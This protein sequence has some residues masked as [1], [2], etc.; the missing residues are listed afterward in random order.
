MHAEAEGGMKDSII[1]IKPKEIERRPG[2]SLLKPKVSV[3]EFS[4]PKERYMSGEIVP[5]SG[6]RIDTDSNT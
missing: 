1:G 2:W 4:F 6:K 5:E 3:I